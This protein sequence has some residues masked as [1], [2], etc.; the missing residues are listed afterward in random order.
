L[1]RAESLGL[2]ASYSETMQLLEKQRIY[3]PRW[4]CVWESFATLGANR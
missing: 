2:I 3:L 4:E 1:Q